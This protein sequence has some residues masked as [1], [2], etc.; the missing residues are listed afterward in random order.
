MDYF[1]FPLF[2][3]VFNLFDYLSFYTYLKW[4]GFVLKF[5]LSIIKLKIKST[6]SSGMSFKIINVVM[7]YLN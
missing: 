1:H 7:S 4:T 6:V 3:R 2:V 5:E